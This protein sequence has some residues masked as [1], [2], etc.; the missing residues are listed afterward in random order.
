[1]N[2]AISKRRKT[3]TLTQMNP[4]IKM[5]LEVNQYYR[6]LVEVIKLLHLTR[7]V[8]QKLQ[9]YAI[10]FGY[11]NRFFEAKKEIIAFLLLPW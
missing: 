10:F 3:D 5:L 9:I 7:F 4:C 6:R 11:S 2:P 8:T 1:M